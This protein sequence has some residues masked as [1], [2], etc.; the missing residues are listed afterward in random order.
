MPPGEGLFFGLFHHDRPVRAHIFIG[1]ILLAV[2]LLVKRKVW[3][4]TASC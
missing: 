4:E 1:V 2:A 3:Q